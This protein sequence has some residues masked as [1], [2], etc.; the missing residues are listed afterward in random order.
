MVFSKP[1]KSYG[2]EKYEDTF[3]RGFWRKFDESTNFPE[4]AGKQI[5][6][7]FNF[8]MEEGEKLK[9]KFALSPVSTAGALA[10]MKAEIQHWDF[11]KTK[12]E[13]QQLWL[14]SD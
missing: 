9:I 14:R 1:L 3:Y 7:Y 6:A 10:N 11:D 13:S 8:N 2:H 12:N 5:R 4:M